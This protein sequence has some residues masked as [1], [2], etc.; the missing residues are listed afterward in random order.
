[1]GWAEAGEHSPLPLLHPLLRP[2]LLLLLLHPLLR[3]PS[4]SLAWRRRPSQLQRRSRLHP[5]L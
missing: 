4:A 3:P 1:M 2:L 5:L